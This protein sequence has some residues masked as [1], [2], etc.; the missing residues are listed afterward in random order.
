MKKFKGV[1]KPVL[2]SLVGSCSGLFSSLV[3]FIWADLRQRICLWPEEVA[4]FWSQ[5]NSEMVHLC[6]ECDLTSIWPNY[7]AYSVSLSKMAPVAGCTFA[8]WDE[9]EWHQQLLAHGQRMNRRLTCTSNKV[10][11]P[12]DI[13]AARTSSFVYVLAPTPDTFDQSVEWLF[14]CGIQWCIL[15]SLNLFMCEKKPNQRENATSLPAHPLIW[16]RE[17]KLQVWKCPKTHII[18]CYSSYW[19]AVAVFTEYLCLT[20]EEVF[21]R[22]AVSGPR[23]GIV[24]TEGNRGPEDYCFTHRGIQV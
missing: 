11:C 4:S 2:L 18:R 10:H 15:V 23:W 13:S 22:I 7:K 20:M 24:V 14:S 9:D 17:N 12:L 1:F 19:N 5:T 16:T 21:S 6:W 8:C 3:R